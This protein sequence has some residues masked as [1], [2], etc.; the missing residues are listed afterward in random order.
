[1]EPWVAFA[2][3]SMLLYGLWGFFPKLASRS[4]DFRTILIIESVGTLIVVGVLLASMKFRVGADLRGTAYALAAGLAG[5]LGS[6]FF[7]LA[8]SRGKASVVVTMTAIYPL[9]VIILSA[10]FLKEPLTLKQGAGIV[11]A[12]AAMVLFSV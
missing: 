11:L 4:L 12:M 6:L 5:A 2:V 1:M 8:L 7:L 9:V 3:L 10:L